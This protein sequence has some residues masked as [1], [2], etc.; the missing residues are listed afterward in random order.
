MAKKSKKGKKGKKQ[1]KK[2]QAKKKPAK[3]RRPSEPVIVPEKVVA[4]LMGKGELMATDL[5]ELGAGGSELKLARTQKECVAR[6]GIVRRPPPWSRLPFVCARPPSIGGMGAF[7]SAADRCAPGYVKVKT[8]HPY[9]GKGKFFMCVL[10]S[11]RPRIKPPFPTVPAG[12]REP[13]PGRFLFPQNVAGLGAIR[14]LPEEMKIPMLLVG[15]GV[16]I[17]ASTVVP[18][19]IASFIEKP[20]SKE[21]ASTISKLALGGAGIALYVPTRTSFTLGLL[22]GTVPSAVEELADFIAGMIEKAAEKAK[23]EKAPPVEGQLEPADIREIEE[24]E[25][26]LRPLAQ[27]PEEE[28]TVEFEPPEGIGQADDY[29][30]EV[31]ETEPLIPAAF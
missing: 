3:K 21:L 2:S 31:P 19:L 23:A 29:D 4:G 16:G 1:A 30:E 12:L 5:L 11:T 24:V 27:G 14:L 15:D 22:L 13:V 6:G 25:E 9:W 17:L 18:R 26:L 8:K 20:E 28:F 7:V 10:P